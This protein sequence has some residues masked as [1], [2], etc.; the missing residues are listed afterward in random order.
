MRTAEKRDPSR[1]ILL[2][3]Q[4]DPEWKMDSTIM[5]QNIDPITALDDNT[6][7]Q[8]LPVYGVDHPKWTYRKVPKVTD[9]R[10]FALSEEDRGELLDME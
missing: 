8:C 4:D 10:S 5:A 3:L 2:D 9:F 7:V 6:Q 1:G